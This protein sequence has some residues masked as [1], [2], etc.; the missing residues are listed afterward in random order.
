MTPFTFLSDMNMNTVIKAQAS[1]NTI[2]DLEKKISS[3]KAKITSNQK[4]RNQI[5]AEIAQAEREQKNAYNMKATYDRSISLLQDGINHAEEFIKLNE[6]Y[7]RE[8]EENI[9]I[10]QEQYDITYERFLQVLRYSYE[11]GNVDYIKMILESENFVNLLA[12]MDRIADIMDNNKTIMKNLQAE[13]AELED[14][15]TALEKAKEENEEYI[16]QLTDKKSKLQ[17]ESNKVNT[18]IQNLN[19]TIE[20]KKK[21]QEEMIQAE[22]NAQNEIAALTKALQAA[23]SSQKTY[24]GGVMKWPVDLSYRKISSG[25]QNRTNPITGRSEFH[26]G[27]DIPAAYGANIYAANDGIVLQVK[28]S[29][30]SYGKYIVVDHGGGTTTLYAHCSSIVKS[31]GAKVYKGDVIA[32]IGSTGMSTGNHIHF[33]VAENGV[34]K[35]PLNYVKQP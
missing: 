23:Q 35:N 18:K 4:Q 34:R 3:S 32:K 15:I 6:E 24:I 5:A 12:R 1:D 7:M 30:S 28:T 29:G 20:E 26:M 14:R 8:I 22:K 31:V 19:A 11:D 33:E 21:M 10:K 2:K 27:I 13:K 25:F 17:S 16:K 9:A